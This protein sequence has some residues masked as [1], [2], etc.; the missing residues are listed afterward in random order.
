MELSGLHLLLTY[1]CLSECDH[2]FVWGSSRQTGVMTIE[3][4][5]AVLKQA[6][7][8]DTLK[9]IYFEGGEPFL[10]YPVLLRGV[11]MATAMGFHVGIV[12]NAYWASTREDALIWLK[13]FAEL[14]EDL[15]V[16]M[17]EYH[18]NH[19]NGRL[20]QNV[21]EAA[22]ELNIA[23]NV[24]SIAQPE[25]MNISRPLGRLPSG[26]S[27]L[28]YRGRAAVKLADRADQF[29]WQLFT[30]CPNEILDNPSRVH[31]DSN[32]NVHICQGVIIGN[33]YD[34]PLGQICEEFHPEFHPVCGPLM[35]GG[36]VEL[37]KKYDLEHRHQ[38]ADACQLCYESRLALRARFP[39]I[40]G[41]D[42]M[43]GVMGK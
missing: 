15:T 34:K 37:V 5:H 4:I 9:W 36:P 16:S 20:L 1:K 32:G 10:Y 28:I 24:V 12:S 38:Y 41:P 11:Q 33:V 13:P 27:S 29:A 3:H 23:L 42:Q 40:L 31:L 17:D 26:K 21:T 2:C 30:F 14:V 18:N 6:R 43:Y 35:K 39:A 25:T 7:E 8:I 22:G 19:A